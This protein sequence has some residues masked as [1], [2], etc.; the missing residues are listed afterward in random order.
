MRVRMVTLA[1]GPGGVRRPGDVIDV[2]S[3]EAR[4]LLEGGYAVPVGRG[5][6]ETA[7]AP[8]AD[9]TTARKTAR[10]RGKTKAADAPAADETAGDD[11]TDG[12][13]AT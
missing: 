2:S 1:A 4:D 12:D 8:A 7:D 3:H 5:E 6:A 10:G 11:A 13:D 9:E